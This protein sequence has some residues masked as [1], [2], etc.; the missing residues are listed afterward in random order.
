MQSSY[1]VRSIYTEEE[2]GAVIARCYD[3]LYGEEFEKY[4]GDPDDFF[5]RE[6]AAN[7]LQDT[8]YEIPD[9]VR[10]Q[11]TEIF[12]ITEFNSEFDY[13]SIDDIEDP[14]EEGDEEGDEGQTIPTNI[15][16][17]NTFN[18]KEA[19]NRIDLDTYNKYDL[20]NLYEA[21]NL[22]ETEKRELA[23]VVYG[24]DE[25]STTPDVIY[26]TLN[27]RYITGREIGMAE[28]VKDGVIHE[29]ADAYYTYDDGERVDVKVIE[30]EEGNFYWEDREGRSDDHFHSR[31]EALDDCE[32]FIKSEVPT[33]KFS[34]M[35][36]S[37]SIEEDANK[38]ARFTLD[39]WVP[40]SGGDDERERSLIASDSIEEIIETAYATDLDYDEAF[41]LTD[42]RGIY[43]DLDQCYDAEELE[44]AI[45]N[46]WRF[47]SIGDMQKTLGRILLPK[48][49]SV[50]PVYKDV[51]GIM[52]EP[53]ETYSEEDL[54]NYWN[55]QKDNDPSLRA[56]SNFN[57]WLRDTLSNMEELDESIE[58]GEEVLNEA[59]SATLSD[60]DLFDPKHIDL[61]QIVKRNAEAEEKARLEQERQE[62]IAKAKEQYKDLLTQVEA[63]TDTYKALELLFEALVP[64]RGKADT[65]AGELVRAIM[66][67]VYRD[68]ND[69]DRFFCGYGIETCGSSAQYLMDMGFDSIDDI[70]EQA[71]YYVNSD[72][73]YTKA[74][75]NV[76]Q[77]VINR[78]LENPFLLGELN[79]V[80]SREYDCREVEE[81]QPRFDYDFQLPN[82]VI[83]HLDAGNITE[84]EV[85]DVLESNLSS[86]HIEYEEVYCGSFDYVTIYG[87][88]YDGY[89]EVQR[90]SMYDESY[91]S[92]EIEDWDDQYGDPDE[93]DY[94]DEDDDSPVGPTDPKSTD[95]EPLPEGIFTSK[96]KKDE[97]A[98]HQIQMVFHKDSNAVAREVSNAMVSLVKEVITNV[99]G[100]A[101]AQMN[102]VV[103]IRK[104]LN[105]SEIKHTPSLLLKKIALYGG[106][107]DSGW[108]VLVDTRANMTKLAKLQ[109]VGDD[110]DYGGLLSKINSEAIPKL[111]KLLDDL[112]A[113]AK[114]GEAFEKDG[115]PFWYFTTHGVQL[116]SIP[117]DVVVL[118]LIE[119]G[120][121]GTY[122]AFDKVLTTDEL[123]QYDM[124]E[125]MPYDIE[126][127][128]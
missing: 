74:I 93:E 124:I 37:K 96:K 122:V 18:L 3:T 73:A 128:N 68:W 114:L 33:V 119:D 36:E 111:T 81:K 70:M 62:R 53:N 5:D 54:K 113:K 99:E 1:R 121:W 9:S 94:E 57:S 29:S 34:R 78:I 101:P 100:G 109:G 108:Q 23:N 75:T 44:D 25:G 115:G 17:G 50:S 13:S 59:P 65:I 89:E 85:I 61:K 97:N 31:E 72:D 10:T 58:D 40:G 98:E 4:L 49:E 95:N 82:G 77:E 39:I 55:T 20:L 112:F 45:Y 86:N 15:I 47:S 125:K 8:S 7:L 84:D 104:L 118:D 90:H 28:R 60:S 106:Q 42:W 12:K 19:L 123:R 66:R 35:N 76:A 30:D 126:G 80:D 120:N 46:E 69:G 32:R 16:R 105:G 2:T 56:Y 43:R 24:Y 27:D 110:R 21:C 14:D 51:S 71:D 22:K 48:R 63:E 64:S 102:E 67:I 103:K 87:L 107:G 41:Y 91:W 38:R 92:Y 26:D 79:D 116:G 127:Y 52:G 6:T 117:R 83:K 88:T 11:I